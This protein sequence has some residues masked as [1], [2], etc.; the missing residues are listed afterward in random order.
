MQQT[1]ERKMNE[2]PDTEALMDRAI[3]LA[4]EEDLGH[5]LTDL[6]TEAIVSDRVTAVGAIYCKQTGVIAGLDICKRVMQRFDRR[7]QVKNHVGDGAFIN[8]VP[9][10]IATFS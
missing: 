5:S 10:T 6:T 7:I 8:I 1:I 4:I 9:T 3:E 2:T